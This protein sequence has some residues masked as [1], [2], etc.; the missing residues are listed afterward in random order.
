MQVVIIGTKL[1]FMHDD[2]TNINVKKTM[3]LILSFII[4]KALFLKL[5][6][7]LKLILN[8]VKPFLLF[9]LQRI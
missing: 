6:V 7:G 4:K 9:Y 2:M 5:R 1:P 3:Y 8:V